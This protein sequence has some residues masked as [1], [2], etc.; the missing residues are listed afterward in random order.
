MSNVKA[1]QL[2]DIIKSGI[3]EESCFARSYGVQQI[4]ERSLSQKASSGSY[5]TP[6]ELH[7]LKQRTQYKMMMSALN[8]LINILPDIPRVNQTKQTVLTECTRYIQYLLA[9][10]WGLADDCCKPQQETIQYLTWD[11]ASLS[12]E[13]LTFLHSRRPLEN[14]P[15]KI[16]EEKK[17][18]VEVNMHGTSHSQTQ[19]GVGDRKRLFQGLS[20]SSSDTEEYLKKQVKAK[21]HK[22]E[23]LYKRSESQDRFGAQ[24]ILAMPPIIQ[25]QVKSKD[26]LLPCLASVNNISEIDSPPFFVVSPDNCQ[27]NSKEPPKDTFEYPQMFSPGSSL[28]NG[29]ICPLIQDVVM[30]IPDDMHTLQPDQPSPYNSPQ[31]LCK[32]DGCFKPILEKNIVTNPV[33]DHDYGAFTPIKATPKKNVSYFRKKD[34]CK[35]NAA[36]D[37]RVTLPPC[38]AVLHSGLSGSIVREPAYFGKPAN[39]HAREASVHPQEA[40]DGQYEMS[41]VKSV[42]NHLPFSPRLFLNFPLKKEK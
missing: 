39:F 27:S 32:S 13:V 1:H 14:A 15:A 12:K 7:R 18:F 2:P 38:D 19:A 31:S 6:S 17:G 35:A 33:A 8:D 20:P 24:E 23:V 25:T 4:S 16:D 30:L 5:L 11:S 22:K 34:L 41:P 9:V 3:K 10:A 28:W 42:T 29:Q 26:K 21:R 36:Y 37:S 40:R